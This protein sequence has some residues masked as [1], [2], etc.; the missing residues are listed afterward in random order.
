MPKSI[1]L[2]DNFAGG[3]SDGERVG[4]P[5]SFLKSAG[6][7]FRSVPDSVSILPPL[8]AES[9]AAAADD[10][11]GLVKWFV[12]DG[13]SLWGYADNGDLY[14]RVTSTWT[15]QR[16]VSTS[17]GQGLDV[18]N[19]YLYYSRNANLGRYGPLSGG[20][21][22]TDGYQS[23]ETT[24]TWAPCHAFGNKLLVG[25]GRYVSSL[26]DATV[27]VAQAVALPP[28]YSVRCMTTVGDWVA[29]GAVKGSNIYDYSDGKVFFWNGTES[30]YNFFINVPEGEPNALIGLDNMLLIIA[31]GRGKMY[32][33]GITS[34]ETEP[35]KSLPNVGTGKFVEVFPGAVTTWDGLTRIGVAGAGDSSTIQR[36]V[37]SYGAINKNY[38]R[39]LS[40]DYPISTGTETGTGVKIGA[41]LA[42]GPDSFYVSWRDGSDYGIDKIDTTALQASAYIETRIG[43][44]DIPHRRKKVVNHQINFE[45]LASG[46]SIALKYKRDRESSWVTAGTAAFSASGAIKTK[47]FPSKKYQAAEVQYRLE[48][49]ASGS[50]SPDLKNL[51]VE[52]EA[53]QRLNA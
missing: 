45:P 43:D 44:M 15:R 4:I 48:L 25:N 11:D 1:L 47:V 30:N 49:A 22:Y 29:I 28:D 16:A 37:F 53:I 13:T 20:A 19:D 42:T 23:L 21:S 31:G 26:D 8:V 18:F 35:V 2:I 32:L 38:N 40:F 33:A 5:G 17:A 41:L 3:I 9:E 14:K 51:V 34:G 39:T 12:N 27:W 46:E 24:T 6:V 52:W 7:D 50:T 36:G 10:V